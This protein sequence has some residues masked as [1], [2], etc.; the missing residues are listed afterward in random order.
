[1]YTADVILVMNW[2]TLLLKPKGK[3]QDNSWWISLMGLK[4]AVRN[5]CHQ[6]YEKNNLKPWGRYWSLINLWFCTATET[7]G[8]MVF[9]QNY[10]FSYQTCVFEM[11]V[12]QCSVRKLNPVFLISCCRYSSSHWQQSGALR[13]RVSAGQCLHCSAITAHYVCALF[14][15]ELCPNNAW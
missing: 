2:K 15:N 1:M 7:V 3:S 10:C 6:K 14:W 12:S 4:S 9:G 11:V 13:V 8:T 5:H